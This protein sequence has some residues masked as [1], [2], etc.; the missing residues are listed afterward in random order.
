MSTKPV[1]IVGILSIILGAL[2]L[3]T[4][5]VVWGVVTSELAAE[6]I[7]TPADAAF[8]PNQPVNNPLTALAQA[9]IINHHALTASNGK[10]YAEL[11]TLATDAT[12]AGNTDLAAKYTA[13]RNTVM[14]GSFLRASLFTSV[15]SYGVCLMAMGV[16]LILGL[17]GWAFMGIAKGLN[18]AVAEVKAVPVEVK[19][20]E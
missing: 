15:L 8:L 9:E 3:V 4:G 12:K 18:P 11:G 10:T 20:A 13:T 5:A 1:R 16:G 6:K 17:I 19:A 2:L 7:T 14:T